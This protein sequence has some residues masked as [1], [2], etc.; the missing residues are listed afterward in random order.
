MNPRPAPTR[1]NE[2]ATIM[3]PAPRRTLR[4]VLLVLLLTPAIVCA[5]AV[6]ASAAPVWKLYSAASSTAAPGSTLE[7]GVTARNVGDTATDGSPYTLTITLPP[8]FT[9]S[10][11]TPSFAWDCSSFTIG[12]TTFTCTSSQVIDPRRLTARIRIH[13]EVGAGAPEVATAG[14]EIAGGGAGSSSAFDPTRITTAP[15]TFGIAAFDVGTTANAAGDVFTQAAGHPYGIITSVEFNSYTHP[16]EGAGWP[17]EPSKDVTVD[18]PPGFVGDPSTLEQCTAEQLA[19]PFR[20]DC[21]AGAQVGA[22]LVFFTGLPAGDPVA[23]YNMVPPQDAPARLGMSVANTMVVLDARVRSGSDYGVSIVNRNSPE[24]LAIQGLEIALWGYPADPA[25]DPER[26]CPGELSP[27]LGG[28]P[29]PS[30]SAVKPFLRMPTSCTAPGVGLPTSIHATSWVDPSDV[31]STSIVSHQPPGFPAPP[32]LWGPVR[33]VTGCGL[34]PFDPE[35]KGTPA[36][37]VQANEPSGFTFELTVPQNDDEIAQSDLKKAVVR[38]P[39]GVRVS[40][41]S[42]FGLTGCSSAQIA[43]TSDAAPTCPDSSKIGAVTLET[44]LLD[45]PLTGSVYLATPFDNPSHSLV[46]LYIVVEGPGVIVKLDGQVQLDPETGQITTIFDDNPQLPFSKL[47]LELDDGPTAP[48]VLPTHCGTYT[49]HAVLTGWSGKTVETDSSFTIARG[50]DGGPCPTK[51]EFTPDFEAGTTNPVAGAHSP[52]VLNLS[53]DDEDEEFKTLSV[54]MPQGILARVKGVPQ[55][56][57]ANAALGTCDAST[58]VGTVTTGAG[59]GSH[60][61]FLDG[62]A[63][64][65]GP[66]KGAPFS[67]VIAVPAV[68]GPFDLGTVVVRSAV[69]IDRHTAQAKVVADP[70][71]TVLQGIPLQIRDV[72]VRIDRTRFFLN[73]TSCKEKTIHGTVGST[74][75]STAHVSKRFQVGDCASLRFRP[76]LSLRVGGKGRTRAGGST[77]LVATLRLGRGQSA[78]KSASVQLPLVYNGRLDVINDACT[79]AEFEA[80]AAKNCANAKTGVAI[81]RTPLLAKPLKGSVYFVEH[82]G[83]GLP[84]MVVALRGEVDVDLVSKIRIPRS[85]KLGTVFASIP[86]VPVTSF[87]LKLFA[88]KNGSIGT[89]ANLCSRKA[90]RATASVKFVGHNG[91]RLAQRQRLK[92]AGCGKR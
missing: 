64:W 82:P 78:I 8:G 15:P 88:G 91:D 90:R 80:N 54:Q 52:F 69:H 81:A 27:L 73:P 39:E 1:S 84:H 60:P 61:F 79:Q 25:H 19:A 17:V 23:V 47:S 13:A 75:G 59:A 89:T 43:L 14:F 56:A 31:K 44:P 68:A 26:S 5:A 71:P 37:P 12:T 67:L 4:R 85:N 16:I 53:R 24:I 6:T 38:L 32:E 77:P 74:E 49:T 66:Y 9:A 35:L 33:G 29:C 70:F 76:R 55:C 46:A 34:V 92:I 45:E 42:A 21:P 20:P 57:P 72:R 10:T 62:K 28:P 87:K 41:S 36:T 2:T 48:V 30:Q 58:R 40:P 63:Y 22:A 11:V 50:A 83:R 7:Y 65:A 3:N 51:P 18:L 86:D